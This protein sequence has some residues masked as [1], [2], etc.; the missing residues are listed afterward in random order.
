MRIAGLQRS[1]LID[2]PDRIACVVFTRGCNLRCPYCHNGSILDLESPLVD[3]DMPQSLFFDFLE[4]RKGLLDGV[5]ITGG[6]PTLQ[7]DLEAFIDEVRRRG[8][9]VKL[10]TNGT[11][12]ELLKGLL[13]REL[14]DYVALDVKMPPDRYREMGGGAE[15]GQK[16]YRSAALL[17]ASSVEQEFRTTVVPG[18]HDISDVEAIGRALGGGHCYIQNFRADNALDEKLRQRSP[19]PQS[20]LEAFREVLAPHVS[21]AGIRF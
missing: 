19:F 18:I 17:M 8:F 2:Y 4:R 10:D 5:C 13:N 21:S 9:R 20:R 6:E 7:P 1:S 14:L 11:S 12:P 16:V 3:E 15:M